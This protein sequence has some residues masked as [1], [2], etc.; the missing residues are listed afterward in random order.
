[1]HR[2]NIIKLGFIGHNNP[3]N[4]YWIFSSR[5]ASNVFVFSRPY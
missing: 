2:E 4:K 5:G 1:V 3:K